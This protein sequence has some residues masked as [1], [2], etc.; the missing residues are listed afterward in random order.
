[1]I[2]LS[3]S[4][5]SL[6]LNYFFK[7]LI[8]LPSSLAVLI[9]ASIYSLLF[10]YSAK[11]SFLESPLFKKHSKILKKFPEIQ[12]SFTGIAQLALCSYKNPI[13]GLKNSSIN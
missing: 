5:N 13:Q 10:S 12:E 1:M 6:I 11:N 8:S 3:L 4:V 9:L 2:P 7:L